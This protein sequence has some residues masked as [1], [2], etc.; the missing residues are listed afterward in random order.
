MAIADAPSGA[1]T[2]PR[3][4]RG[5]EDAVTPQPVAAT[6]KRG[7]TGAA[8]KAGGKKAAAK[9]TAGKTTAGKKAVSGKRTPL[10]VA[11]K[12]KVAAKTMT[13]KKGARKG[14]A[15]KTATRKRA[16]RPRPTPPGTEPLTKSVLRTKPFA[17]KP[18]PI[19]GRGAFATRDIPKEARIA[20]YFGRRITPEEADELYPYPDDDSVPHHTFLFNL[21]EHTVLDGSVDGDSSR[22]I[23]HSCEPNCEAVI[24]DARIF[25]ETLRDL[26]KGEELLYDYQFIL[27]EPHTAAAKKRYPCYCGAKKCR[28]TILA[29][30]K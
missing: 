20:E 28:G 25:I 10:T 4:A 18:S 23:N 11:A 19:A 6:E 13:A 29:R 27:D 5:T 3:S 22:F 8:K 2:R 12:K 7:R 21:D 14:A 1:I 30:K 15:T 16:A 26:R 24:E 9:K 17:L